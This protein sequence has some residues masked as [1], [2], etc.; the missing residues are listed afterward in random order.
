MER[1]LNGRLI[2]AMSLFLATAVLIIVI[3]IFDYGVGVRARIGQGPYDDFISCISFQYRRDYDPYLIGGSV[4]FYS[5]IALFVASLIYMFIKKTLRYL[6]LPIIGIIAFELS[7]YILQSGHH[8]R[9]PQ[10]SFN[11]VPTWYF[12]F[13]MFAFIALLCFG[14]G[15]FVLSF[16]FPRRLVKKASDLD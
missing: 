6:G 9:L 3:L 5:G 10:A 15:A 8:A 16:V 14:L 4:I 2:A 1:R 11:S 7:A 12:G 13:S